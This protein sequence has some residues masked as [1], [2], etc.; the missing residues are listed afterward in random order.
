MKI[1]RF[2]EKYEMPDDYYDI[3]DEY[4]KLIISNYL[5]NL[6]DDNTL[7]KSIDYFIKLDNLD[8]NQEE[9][10]LNIFI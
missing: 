2:N 10:V 1:K 8:D 6:N 9:Q 3:A 7:Q 5:D 4:A